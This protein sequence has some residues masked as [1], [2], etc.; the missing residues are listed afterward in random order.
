LRSS[1]R[2]ASGAPRTTG[3]NYDATIVA[4]AFAEPQVA[5]AGAPQRALVAAVERRAVEVAAV[6]AGKDELVV[7]GPEWSLAEAGEDGGDVGRHR[8]ERISP[9]L[10][11]DRQRSL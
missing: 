6:L 10:G 3:Y 5:Q 8:T 2:C 11:P 9:L 4:A 7:A 1:S